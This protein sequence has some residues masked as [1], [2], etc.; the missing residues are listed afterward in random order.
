MILIGKIQYNLN[1][2]CAKLPSI[3]DKSLEEDPRVR[4]C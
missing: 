3:A 2:K 1:E 4:T